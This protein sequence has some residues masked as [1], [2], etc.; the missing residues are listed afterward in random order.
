[1]FGILTIYDKWIPWF[2]GPKF[3]F[4]N[5]VMPFFSILVVIIPLGMAICR[6]FLLPSGRVK[7]Y[8]RS[9][10]IGAMINAISNIILL[11]TIGFFGVV[12]STI[13]A[14][15]FVTYARTRNLLKTTAFRFDIRRII[16]C[17][18]SG[19]VMCL[20]TRFITAS[21]SA[22]FLTNL[23]Q[24]VIGVSIYF[25]LTTL[26]RVNALLKSSDKKDSTESKN[27][28]EEL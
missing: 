11:P 2:L 13:A 5:N 6:Q 26:F 21:M 15:F 23:L 16:L 22:S 17:F 10:V 27:I 24:G 28:P 25:S 9:F 1:M 7:E 20:T 8:N 14:E 12:F 18:F 3:M 19:L 4:V